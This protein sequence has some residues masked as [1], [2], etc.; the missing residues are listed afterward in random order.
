MREKPYRIII[1]VDLSPKPRSH[2]MSAASIL[3]EYFACD[4]EFMN[5]TQNL[6]PDLSI[7]G[8]EWEIKSPIGNSYNSIHKNMR[9]ALHQSS[10][11]VVDL[12]RSKLHPNRATGYIRKFLDHPNTLKRV[13]VITKAGKVLV[14]K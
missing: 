11:I 13:L 3:S 7:G 2:E 10:N 5:R 12:R 4:V 1:P 6:S 14:M 9:E 8:I